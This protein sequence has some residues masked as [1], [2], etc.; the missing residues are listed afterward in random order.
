M[1]E[2]VIIAIGPLTLWPSPP[3]SSSSSSIDKDPQLA[4]NKEMLLPAEWPA[5]GGESMKSQ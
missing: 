1:R 2:E 4:E 3:P 5:L